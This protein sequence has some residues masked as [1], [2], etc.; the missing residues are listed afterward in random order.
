[1]ATIVENKDGKELQIPNTKRCPYCDIDINDKEEYSRLHLFI[2]G[3]EF[4]TFWHDD[5]LREI[6]HNQNLGED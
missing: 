4:T 2:E 3:H 6:H 1:M 5:C